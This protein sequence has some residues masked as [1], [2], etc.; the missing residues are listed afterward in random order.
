MANAQFEHVFRGP[1][2]EADDIEGYG[3]Y[4]G[5][6]PD[7]SRV[8]P[9]QWPLAR[10]LVTGEPTEAQ[11][12]LV[13]RDGVRITTRCRGAAIRD[14]DG[15]IVAGLIIVDDV[16]EQVAL[17]AA[18]SRSREEAR[19]ERAELSVSRRFDASG[20]LD[21]PARRPGRVPERRRAGYLGVSDPTKLHIALASTVHPDDREHTRERWA[22]GEA[23]G[24][25]LPGGAPPARPRRCLPLVSDAW[26]AAPRPGRPNRQMV[27]DQHRD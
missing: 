13:R 11:I 25:S 15:T 6:F 12:D 20:G 8:E 18:P 14:D 26:G 7:G 3:A 27:R 17:G 21:H 24:R 1:M 2:I 22:R 10:S 23:H 4:E 5:Y 16:T 9:H 19:G